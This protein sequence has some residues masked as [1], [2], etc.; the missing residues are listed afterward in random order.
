MLLLL[1]ILVVNRVCYKWPDLL[2]KVCWHC[3]NALHMIKL[4]ESKRISGHR[5]W[6]NYIV[7][8]SL[9]N[10]T[11]MICRVRSVSVT[12]D[13]HSWQQLNF[14]WCPFFLGRVCFSYCCTMQIPNPA[15]FGVR[16][17]CD[18]S[19]VVQWMM[20]QWRLICKLNMIWDIVSERH[21][22]IFMNTWICCCCV[23]LDISWHLIVERIFSMDASWYLIVLLIHVVLQL[24]LL[25]LL[26]NES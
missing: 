20:S 7:H 12:I 10:H 4:I 25:L 9:P 8:P 21:V 14:I 11:L 24:L 13:S 18:D 6:L 1:L 15:F 5:V 2:C 26:L 19:A 17:S 16:Q 23:L 22:N 3:C